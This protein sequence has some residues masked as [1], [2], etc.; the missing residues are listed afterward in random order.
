[1]RQMDISFALTV[2]LN[3]LSPAAPAA[4]SGERGGEA[5][6]G[7]AAGL[8]PG[9]G[10]DQ[11]QEL[12]L[13][14]RL[15]G[16]AHTLLPSPL[17]CDG[18][19]TCP[20]YDVNAGLKILIVCY[21]RQL[22]GDWHRIARCI[23]ELGNRLQGGLALWS[24]LD[25]VVTHRTP[26]FVLLF[27]LIKYKILQTI[28]DNEQEYYYQQLIRDRIK[29]VSLPTPKSFGCMF[30]DLVNELKT[31]KEDLVAWKLG[32]HYSR[33]SRLAT[34]YLWGEPE[35]C[36]SPVTEGPSGEV[37]QSV[38]F[39]RPP[40]THRPSFTELTPDQQSITRLGSPPGMAAPQPGGLEGIA[41]HPLMRN[42]CAEHS[43]VVHVYLC[44]QAPQAPSR[45]ESQREPQR[46][47]Q[48][49]QR[50]LSI[51]LHS[52]EGSGRRVMQRFLR[53]TSYPE[54]EGPASQDQGAVVSRDT[55]LSAG[56]ALERGVVNTAVYIA[57]SEPRLFRK[58]TLLIKKKGSKKSMGSSSLTS[59]GAAEGGATT[60]EETLQDSLPEGVDSTDPRQGGIAESVL[61]LSTRPPSDPLRSASPGEPLSPAP[62]RPQSPSEGGEPHKPRH[63]LQRQKAQSRKT[64]RLGKSRRGAGWAAPDKGAGPDEAPP[65]PLAEEEP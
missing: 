22:V 19:N 48:R 31:L 18:T 24:F 6:L 45:S 14:D 29:G 13:P 10:L 5:S 4:P 60:D 65:P 23:R 20:F 27:P 64:F 59:V 1:M 50:G 8:G 30:V 44:L 2:V 63:R 62:S 36:K 40:G 43:L 28:C 38:S 11:P 57:S 42:C 58:S 21:E 7:G 51:R 61:P 55:L 41:L 15:P 49:E 56:A 34:C 26:L 53:R 46:A 54:E 3:A 25:F 12:P 39:S 16:Q 9:E 32:G 52:R 47:S 35:R 37:S 33:L 17:G